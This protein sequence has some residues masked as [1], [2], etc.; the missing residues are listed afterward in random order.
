MTTRTLRGHAA[1]RLNG[2]DHLPG[3]AIPLSFQPDV[4]V[5]KSRKR[6]NRVHN[7]LNLQRHR[8]SLVRCFVFNFTHKPVP[9]GSA[10]PFLHPMKKQARCFELKRATGQAFEPK[11]RA[12]LRSHSP[13]CLPTLCL[14][15][16]NFC[17][18]PLNFNTQ[19][20]FDSVGVA[21]LKPVAIV[22]IF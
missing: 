17:Y 3:R 2:D 9:E 10:M 21:K 12:W 22:P 15:T 19:Y 18:R 16:H 4:L 1:M 11:V 14:F 13:T 20:R 7:G 6:L 5:H 8:G